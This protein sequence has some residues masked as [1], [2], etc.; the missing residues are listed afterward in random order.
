M[1]VAKDI[2]YEMLTPDIEKLGYIFKKSKT[3]YVKSV[4]ALDYQIDFS[5]DGRGGLT[6]LNCVTGQIS[7]PFI[8]KASKKIPH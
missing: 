5:W 6:F 4:G 3:Q 7:M 8:K 2:F 1:S